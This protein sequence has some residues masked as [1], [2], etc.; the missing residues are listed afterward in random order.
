M[1]V[2]AGQVFLRDEVSGGV[3]LDEI[4][5]CE[6]ATRNVITWTGDSIVELHE[7]MVE[8]GV[9]RATIVLSDMHIKGEAIVWSLLADGIEYYDPRD[10]DGPEE[11]FMVAVGRGNEIMSIDAAVRGCRLRW[12]GADTNGAV[13][14]ATEC[15][16]PVE[17]WGQKVDDLSQFA[18][19]SVSLAARAYRD[20][21]NANEE[22]F[23]AMFPEIPPAMYAFVH[24]AYRSGL[25]ALGAD[26]KFGHC[27]CDV[28]KAFAAISACDVFMSED[29]ISAYPYSLAVDA[30]PRGMPVAHG[31][32]EPPAGMLWIGEVEF[33]FFLRDPAHVPPFIADNEMA[34]QGGCLTSSED[35]VAV[36]SSVEWETINKY[37]V[38]DVLRWGEWIAFDRLDTEVQDRLLG[39]PV[40]E[41]FVK[42]KYAEGIC[43]KPA[44]T[45]INGLIGQFARRPRFENRVPELR[46]DD[47]VT[48]SVTMK[49]KPQNARYLP[50]VVFVVAYQRARLL[51][52]LELR[53]GWLYCDTDGLYFYEKVQ[54]VD[55]LSDRDQTRMGEW[56]KDQV[57]NM[58]I[59]W[60]L[61]KYVV[62]GGG[63]PAV[64]HFAGV[65][66]LSPSPTISS[67]VQGGYFE[68][69]VETVK[70]VPGGAKVS[71][72]RRFW[73]NGVILEEGSSDRVSRILQLADV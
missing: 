23:D 64:V 12:V 72:E 48:W 60:G 58:F 36:V 54:G 34:A 20:I 40:A 62:G 22:E 10:E 16:M 38:V 27:G 63:W 56:K 24:K 37:Y 6:M 32:G 1:N 9:D 46:F 69:E 68:F 29:M 50:I 67:I 53:P 3:A 42:K 21:R 15:Y 61:K 45:M 7:D 41:M 49:D 47:T 5:L 39:K 59:A 65:P 35:H 52:R 26:W 73:R 51:R 4:E 71:Y 25:C 30:L 8:I 11:C 31:E 70:H 13:S 19:T 44:K 33:E 18:V 17:E 55:A 66:G 28:K 2:Y 14:R 43:K 57:G